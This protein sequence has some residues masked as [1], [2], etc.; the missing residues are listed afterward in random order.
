MFSFF[1][2]RRRQQILAASPS[3]QFIGTIRKNVAVYSLLS[4]VEQQSLVE[5]AKVIAGERSFY[6]V[7][8]F[9]LTDDTIVTISAQAALLVLHGEGY[10]FDRVGTILVHNNT[11]KV[12]VVHPLGGAVLVE[13]GVA[14]DGQHLEQG[15]IRLAWN[16]VLDGGRDAQ[17]GS[18]V[19]LHEF[20]HH[21]DWLDGEH[22]GVPPLARASDRSHWL[23]VIDAEIDSLRAD[24]HA[25]YDTLLP[26]HA[27]DN[28]AELFAYS[29]EAFFELP[30]ALAEYHPDLFACLLS[31]YI[32]DPRNWFP[33]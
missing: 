22:D 16:Q 20:A 18:N 17:D 8:D 29:T 21:L 3:A 2:N 9:Q 26:G 7:G 14:I 28:P 30:H 6:A 19:V 25:G 31:F 13:E 24:F 1:K 33:E 23:E 27:A 15:E 11:P 32:T 5:I 10:Y 12:K 4:P